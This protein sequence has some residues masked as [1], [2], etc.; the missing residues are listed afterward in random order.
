MN[1]AVPLAK[2]EQLATTLLIATLAPVLQDIRGQHVKQILTN[3]AVLHAKM[4][5]LAMT[6]L[7]ATHAHVYQNMEVHSVRQVFKIGKYYQ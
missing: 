7:T 6:M 5:V 2:M 4:E 3:A 1:A